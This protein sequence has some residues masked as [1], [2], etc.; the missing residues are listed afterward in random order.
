MKGVDR[1]EGGSN[2]SEV[3][4]MYG[5]LAEVVTLGSVKEKL[6]HAKVGSGGE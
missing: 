1:A 2:A 5:I 3:P 6:N 4:V